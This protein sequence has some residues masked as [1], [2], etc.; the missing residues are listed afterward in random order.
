[1]Y[2][3]IAYTH[4]QWFSS[5][6]L[7]LESIRTLPR[8]L[9]L[10]VGAYARRKHK[11]RPQA[12]T[13]DRTRRNLLS[14]AVAAAVNRRLCGPLVM[15]R[16]MESDTAGP[17]SRYSQL[18]R[19]SYRAP[20]L[21]LR[22]CWIDC[23]GPVAWLHNLDGR[24]GCCYCC[25]CWCWVRRRGWS[26]GSV[27]WSVCLCVYRFVQRDTRG[28][29][30]RQHRLSSS[31]VTSSVMS[32]PPPPLAQRRTSTPRPLLFIR[33]STSSCLPRMHQLPRCTLV[34]EG[35]PV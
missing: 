15:G 17:R 23:R 19:P 25:C 28:P 24:P 20:V 29:V 6:G 14:A 4:E 30:A 7:R 34:P 16:R 31:A 10:K 26:Y 21:L 13:S 2:T 5:T 1:M 35:S 32:S 12:T 18:R 3:P 22:G 11:Q 33:L 9:K 27:C 8:D